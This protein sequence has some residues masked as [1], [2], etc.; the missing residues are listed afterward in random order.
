MSAQVETFDGLEFRK[1]SRTSTRDRA[2][3]EAI[4]IDNLD[5]YLAIEDILDMPSTVD[6]VEGHRYDSVVTEAQIDTKVDELRD[7]WSL[8]MDP[9]PS[10]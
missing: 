3:A 2:K 8:G 4:L 6:W 10:L 1:H 7:A 5:R 9:I